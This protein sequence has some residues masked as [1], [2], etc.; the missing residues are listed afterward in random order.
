MKLLI[1]LI[2]GRTRINWPRKRLL[3]QL[4]LSSPRYY[5]WKKRYGQVNVSQQQPKNHWL[6]PEEREAIVAYAKHNPQ[7]GYRRLSYMMLDD[8]VAAASPSTV[9]RVLREA[10]MLNEARGGTS[11]KG[12]GFVQPERPHEHWH[13]DISYINIAGTFFYFISVLDGYS[14][15][16]VHWELRESMKE[17]DV[18]L[19]IQRG[20]EKHPAAKPRIISDNGAH[21]YGA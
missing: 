13:S 15:Y 9:Y 19:V 21:I 5:D 2:I 11:K 4:S 20:L 6:R 12:T 3:A 18:E 14:R 1:S 8:D 16:M 10:D 17:S 7:E